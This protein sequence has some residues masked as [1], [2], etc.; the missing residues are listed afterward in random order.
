MKMK[1]Q[2]QISPTGSYQQESLEKKVK[3]QTE[4]EGKIFPKS[5]RKR[6]EEEEIR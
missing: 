2:I 6:K 1:P 5:Q 3:L 4:F